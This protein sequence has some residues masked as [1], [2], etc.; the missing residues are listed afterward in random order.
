[1]P[2]LLLLDLDGTLVDTLGFIIDCFRRSVEPVVK[3]LPTDEEI[4]ATFGPAEIECIARLLARFHQQQLL[5]SILQPEHIAGSAARFHQL[6]DD[7]HAAGRVELY[8]G[9]RDVINEAKA[10][11]WALGVFTGKG[12]ASAL[13]TI[14]HLQLTSLFDVIVTSDDVPHPKPAP[15]GVE[16]AALQAGTICSRTY[17]VGDNPADILAG[18]AAGAVSVAALWGA[19]NREETRNAKPA[20]VLNSPHELHLL[21]RNWHLK[22]N[23]V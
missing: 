8:P 11:G 6:Y 14:A 22:R 18:N 13:V 19:F 9:M 5:R 10:N 4:V 15:D 21:L 2:P 3:R 7:G 20:Y 17:F 23:G 1:M 12:R 16:K